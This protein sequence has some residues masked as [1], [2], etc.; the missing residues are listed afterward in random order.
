[1]FDAHTKFPSG[2]LAGNYYD[3]GNFDECLN[4]ESK[5]IQGKYC[6]G[7]I[8]LNKTRSFIVS[9]G[10]VFSNFLNSLEFQQVTKGGQLRMIG[11]NPHYIGYHYA[12]C[13]PHECTAEDASKIYLLSK[14]DEKY[15]Y[16]K[17]TMP[18]V[19]EGE[20]AAM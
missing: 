14:F 12:I 13:I 5:P 10:T 1:M 7:T 6:L 19:S 17:S 9:S 16:S 11:N 8:P 20:I 2:I 3:L 15:C 18:Q 4:I